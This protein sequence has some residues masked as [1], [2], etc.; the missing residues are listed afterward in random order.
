M[1]T[2]KINYRDLLN[3]PNIAKLLLALER[4][5]HR[6]NIDFYLVGAVARNAWLKGIHDKEPRRTTADIDFAVLIDDKLK[7]QLLRDYL[8][9]FEEFTCYKENNFVLIWKDK[10][11]VDLIP[12]GQIEDINGDIKIDGTGLTSINMPG[13]SEIYQENLPQLSLEDNQI[14]KFCTLPGIVLLKLFAWNDRPEIRRD[15]IKDICDILNHFFDIYSEEIYEYHNDLFEN[16]ELPIISAI[17]LGRELRRIA[18]RNIK[19]YLRLEIILT[20]NTLE[21][22]QSPIAFIMS[23]HFNNTIEENFDLLK[24]IKKGLIE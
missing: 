22:T 6:F 7:Y 5:F 23:E 16:N 14:F 2:Y 8:I 20:Q 9:E 19:I 17:T 4:G 11:E 13:F 12:F 15:D 21:I 24:A 1:N 3:S 10:T 18:N